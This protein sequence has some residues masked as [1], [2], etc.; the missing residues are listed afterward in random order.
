MHQK[1]LLSFGIFKLKVFG[2]IWA[3]Y[4]NIKKYFLLKY[5]F[6]KE[7]QDNKNYFGIGHE[8]FM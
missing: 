6:R 2:L 3:H 4:F 7:K 1:L 5:E 8:Y